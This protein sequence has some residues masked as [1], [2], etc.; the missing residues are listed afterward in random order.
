VKSVKCRANKVRG[1]F[2]KFCNSTIKKNGNATNYTLFFSIIPTEFSAF[3]TFFWQA[4]NSTKIEIFRL[5]PQLLL[6]SFLEHFIVRIAD[7]RSES[8]ASWHD[9]V[10]N[11]Y[12]IVVR[13]DCSFHSQLPCT[14]TF[15][16]LSCQVSE[17]FEH[18]STILTT[19]CSRK[20]SGGTD[21]RFLFTGITVG[22]KNVANAINS[23]GI[24][25]KNK[26]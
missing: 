13:K 17:L 1:A 23:V 8:F 12:A 11:E 9:N 24:I 25:L 2:K 20:L 26:A 10:K 3:A 18:L 19:K 22:Q 21:R 4:V 6:D 14:I 5:S 15:I 7:R 16:T